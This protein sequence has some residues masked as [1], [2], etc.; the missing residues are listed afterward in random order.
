MYKSSKENKQN[1][2]SFALR[3]ELK[4]KMDKLDDMIACRQRLMAIALTTENNM[5]ME[6]PQ[7]FI[8]IIYHLT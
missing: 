7:N 4:W 5:R 1:S 3:R 2:L 6:H 8:K